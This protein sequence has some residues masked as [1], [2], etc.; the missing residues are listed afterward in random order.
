M[1]YNVASGTP[2]TPSN[3]YDE[4]TLAAV[5]SQPIGPINSRYGPWTQSLDFKIGRNFAMRNMQSN[6]YILVQNAFNADNAIS[7]FTGT[8]SS[9][10]T[11]FLQTN[12]GRDASSK[13][14]SEGID[15]ARLLSDGA[16]GSLAVQQSANGAVRNAG[17]V[18][19]GAEMGDI[20]RIAMKWKCI[21]AGLLLVAVAATGAWARS[22]APSGTSPAPAKPRV[23]ELFPRATRPSTPRWSTTARGST[24]TT[25]SMVVTNTGSFAYD[26][27]TGNAGLEFPKGTTKTA[28]FAAGSGW[29]PR[30]QGRRV[31]PSPSTPTS[32]VRV[33]W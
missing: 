19:T 32:T 11:A 28:V 1:L 9:N 8:G 16:R 27:G 14:P 21:V 25:S 7:V 12:D 13:L 33:R 31:S 18:L 29:A 3:V 20:R 10:T 2:Y 6:I 22:N 5:S 30:S 23:N 24:S 17:R 15:P 26:K 4:V